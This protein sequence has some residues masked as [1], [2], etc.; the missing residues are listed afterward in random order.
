MVTAPSRPWDETKH[1]RDW[2]GEF[3]RVPGI[4]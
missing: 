3:A 1:P 4:H 2:R